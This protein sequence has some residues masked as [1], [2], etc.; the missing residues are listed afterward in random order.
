[1]PCFFIGGELSHEGPAMG[2]LCQS[3]GV[4]ITTSTP[5]M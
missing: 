5:L 1:M 4:L 2:L 3:E